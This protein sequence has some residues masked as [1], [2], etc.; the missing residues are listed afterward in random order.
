V[1]A[2]GEAPGEFDRRGSHPGGVYP[3][4]GLGRLTPQPEPRQLEDVAVVLDALAPEDQPE[5]LDVL[6]GPPE[7]SVVLDA[8][9]PLDD[10]GAAGPQPHPEPAVGD[11]LERGGGLAQQGR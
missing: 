2:V 1:P 11:L 4:C 10:R 6:A 5:N 8:V 9:P 3:R 7:R